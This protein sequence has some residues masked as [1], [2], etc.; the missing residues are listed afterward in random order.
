MSA[1]SEVDRSVV[2]VD[3]AEA[4][5]FYLAVA[6][7]ERTYSKVARQFKVSDVRVGQVARQRGWQAKALEVDRRAD[8]ASITLAVRTREQRIKK[9]LGI[10]DR[11]LDRYTTSVN[12]LELKPSDLPQL[13]KLAE[14][15]VG[16]PTDR[17]EVSVV[18]RVFALVIERAGLYVERDRREAFLEE[19]RELEAS[20]PQPDSRPALDKS[21]EPVLDAES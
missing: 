10:I 9:T 11:M 19:M 18:R 20:L 14:L 7:T 3:W 16:E 15:L 1:G 17:V 5:A 6:P 2:G 8:E 4:E 21:V 12:A 13:V